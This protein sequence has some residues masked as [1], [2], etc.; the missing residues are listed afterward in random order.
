M[1]NAGY[2]S[3]TKLKTPH[4]F[5]GVSLNSNHTHPY[6]DKIWQKPQKSN[7][8]THTSGTIFDRSLG[9]AGMHLLMEAKEILEQP[10]TGPSRL[11][12]K[13][14]CLEVGIQ[15]QREG[16]GKKRPKAKW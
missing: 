1:L 2:R 9:V 14:Y 8:Q 13:F 16:W 10:I 4:R 7:P 5:P 15:I 11:A 3:M 12:W 6:C